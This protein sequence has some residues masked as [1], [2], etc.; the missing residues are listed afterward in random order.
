[1]LALALA[2]LPLIA[3]RKTQTFVAPGGGPTQQSDK[4]TGASNGSL[5]LQGVVPGKGELLLPLRC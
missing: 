3:A 2:L 5:P 4:Y 1:M